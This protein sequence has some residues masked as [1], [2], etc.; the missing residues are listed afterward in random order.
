[1]RR[2]SSQWDITCTCLSLTDYTKYTYRYDQYTTHP[3]GIN[4]PSLINLSC[5]EFTNVGDAIC[6][7]V[8]L[9]DQMNEGKVHS[10]AGP[11]SFEEAE[12]TKMREFVL[13]IFVYHG[14][15]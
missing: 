1:M 10:V 7:T 4:S 8:L 15:S 9:G 5:L 13:K 2:Y 3:D 6:A 12:L 11:A 14:S